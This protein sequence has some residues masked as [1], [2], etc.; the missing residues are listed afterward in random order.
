MTLGFMV[1]VA[2][3]TYAQD[4]GLLGGPTVTVERDAPTLVERDLEGRL[5][6]LE[7]RAEVAAIGLLGLTDAEREAV[8]ILILERA[9]LVDGIVF[10]NLELL[11]Q[12]Q[13]ARSSMEPGSGGRRTGE[14]R[15]LF[16]KMMDMIAPLRERE[17]LVDHYAAALPEESRE[18]YRAIVAEWNEAQ[19]SESRGGMQGMGEGRREPRGARG[20]GRMGGRMAGIA[21]IRTELKASYERGAADRTERLDSFIAK[22]GLTPEQEGQ[23][24]GM[25][26]DSIQAAEG[27]PSQAQRAELFR[28]V[29]EMLEPDQRRKAIEALRGDM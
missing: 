15:E 10:D 17:P 16:M 27:E 6:P 12:L 18:H 1:A 3:G 8:D 25:I 20:G 14:Q 28:K 23:V 19:A 21:G 26:S 5:R 24:R 29:L 11:T 2:G 13:S 22:L 9:E 7:T 4:E